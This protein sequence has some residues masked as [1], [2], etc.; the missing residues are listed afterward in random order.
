MRNYLFLIVSL[1]LLACLPKQNGVVVNHIGE[2]RE[3]MH[4]GQFQARVNLDT[5]TGSHLFGLGA[6]DSLSGE[7]LVLDNHIYSSQVVDSAVQVM[8][9][10]NVEATLFVYAEVNAWDTL[11]VIDI[12]DIEGL[13]EEKATE[14]NIKGPFPFMLIGKPKNLEYHVINFNTSMGDIN[15][16]KD[17]AFKGAVNNEDLTILGF[18]ATNAQGIYTHHDSHVHM[19]FLNAEGTNSGH[20]DDADFTNRKF[21]LLI[22][23]S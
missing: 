15:N 8:R 1:F 13:L 9:N 7:I 10:S 23:K 5:L 22:P 14:L 4:K 12:N 17:G 20:V 16:H 19:H 21:K 6:M 18:H 11:N 2:L 3:I